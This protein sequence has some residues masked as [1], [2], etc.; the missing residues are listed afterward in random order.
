MGRHGIF[1]FG[2]AVLL[3]VIL[4]VLSGPALGPIFFNTRGRPFLPP[5]FSHPLGVDEL[6]R[7]VLILL[8]ESGK[9]SLAIGLAAAAPAT[10][11]GAVV[12]IA[13]GYF[14][15]RTDAVS[16]VLCDVFLLIPGLPLMIV[17]AS[18]LKPGFRSIAPTIALLSW[19]GTARVVRASVMQ[20]RGMPFI[21]ATRALGV[22][23]FH[24][25]LRHVLPH[26]RQLVLARGCLAVSGAML[27]EAGL[28]FLGLGDPIRSSW[29]TMLYNAFSHG[30]VVNGFYWWY[31]PP[32]FCISLTVLAFTL[33]GLAFEPAV[34]RSVP[35]QVRIRDGRDSTPCSELTASLICGQTDTQNVILSVWS[36][37]VEFPES[38]DMHRRVLDHVDFCVREQEKVALIGESGSGKS[39]LLTTL[40]RLLPGD[41][42]VSGKILFRGRDLLQLSDRQMR[43]LRRYRL[44]YVPQAAGN[45]LNPVLSIGF[46]VAESICSNCRTSRSSAYAKANDFLHRMGIREVDLRRLDYPHRYSGG[47]KQRALLAMAL[48]READ[49]LLVD[50]PTKGLDY[51]A[52]NELLNVLTEFRDEAILMVTHDLWFAERFA[53]RIA[54]MTGSTVVEEASRKHFFSNPLHPYSQALLAALPSH[55]MK[56]AL[57]PTPRNADRQKTGCPFHRECRHA[58]GRCLE[59]P[60]LFLR[61]GCVVRCWLYAS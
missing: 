58:T 18:Y 14:R 2:H 61:D 20:V 56:V 51:K 54:V 50:E 1:T 30:A 6:G 45:A 15:G 35:F 28:S 49:L 27:A 48:A 11:F 19:A 3:S 31:L 22:S 17:V 7:D 24:V 60:P 8:F 53:D 44:A 4:S 33:S 42:L 10:L 29:G 23:H 59:R 21:V 47:M 57:A 52:K 39:L 32:V 26:V 9:F 5:N 46:Q 55:G 16:K 40:L 12:G 34:P 41:A 36:L 37:T 43:E 13:S 25:M 38:N